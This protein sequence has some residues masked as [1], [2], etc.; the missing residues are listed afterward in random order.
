MGSNKSRDFY[1]GFI[2]PD[3][4]YSVENIT[5]SSHPGAPSSYTQEGN[6]TGTPALSSGTSRMVL[7]GT[8]DQAADSELSITTV[9]GGHPGVEGGGFT[10]TDEAN[11]SDAFGRDG[12]QIITSWQEIRSTTVV[13]GS[14]PALDAIR[15]QDGNLLCCG[16][17]TLLAG[18]YL[19]HIKRYGYT[20]G[21]WTSAATITPDDTGRQR[22]PALLQLP[23]GRV[24]LFLVAGPGQTQ[25]DVM[26]SDDAGSTWEYHAYRVL[27]TPMSTATRVLRAEYSNGEILLIC[28]TGSG[29]TADASVYASDD[30]ACQF[31]RVVT[32]WA[33]SVDDNAAA[34]DIVAST[35]GGFIIIYADMDVGS[36]TYHSRRI[37]SAFVSPS[38]STRVQVGGGGGEGAA[39][40]RDEDL[41]LYAVTQVVN[42]STTGNN[43][44]VFRSLDEGDSWDAF[45]A[46]AYYSGDGTNTWLFGFTVAST[47]GK[48]A[49]ITRWTDDAGYPATNPYA[50]F[51]I[52]AIW[53]GGS[54]THTVP[55]ESWTDSFKDTEYITWTDNQDPSA[56][57]F[58]GACYLPV[59][60]PGD[61][62]WGV[63][64]TG[65]STLTINADLQLEVSCAAGM[66]AAM[67]RGGVQ[68]ETMDADALF[69]EFALSV[70]SG[71]DQTAEEIYARGRIT[72]ESSYDY[73]I[74]L[75]F[76][77]NG[78]TA[79]DVNGASVGTTALTMGNPTHFRV[80]VTKGKASVWYTQDRATSD[81]PAIS[82][83]EAQSAVTL[84]D[85]GAG[86][87]A[88]PTI[89]WGA[90][91]GAGGPST[92]AWSM[93]GYCFWAGGWTPR[94]QTASGWDTPEA[95]HPRSYSTAPELIAD[96]AYVHAVSGPTTFGDSWT[97]DPEYH[98]Q[99]ANILPSVAPSP[100]NTWRGS[101][102]VSNII[103]FQLTGP[104][105][106][107]SAFLQDSPMLGFALFGINFKQAILQ[108]KVGAS[109][110]DVA[111]I[112]A[113][114]GGFQ[115]PT[116]YERFGNRVRPEQSTNQFVSERF[117]NWG[118]FTGGTFKMDGTYR[119]IG[120]NT[121]GMFTND[122]T[123]YPVFSLLD[124]DSADPTSGDCEV[125]SP[126]ACVIVSGVTPYNSQYFRLVI[127]AQTTAGDSYVEIGTM[128]VGPVVAFSSQYSW[129]RSIGHDAATTTFDLPDG[130]SKPRQ[131]G[132][133]AREF[134]FGWRDGVDGS[135]VDGF[136][137]S[138][139]YI[140]DASGGYMAAIGA[141]LYDLEGIFTEL[142][143]SVKPL[144]Y[145]PRIDQT[146]TNDQFTGPDRFALCRMT[147]SLNRQT[148]LGNEDSS[149]LARL[150]TVTLKEIK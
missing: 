11:D 130:S 97:I 6:Y 47:A 9:R 123:K 108:R 8:G 2:L 10:W 144:V 7:E 82:W 113:A 27:G 146:D 5:R 23:S 76:D 38:G 117:V 31:T 24:L 15:L 141:Q 77:A 66:S 67:S 49:L 48:T 45:S 89:S 40:W 58:N 46:P 30:L 74:S 41:T 90:L 83:T 133:V 111:T 138:P 33:S 32:S 68:H 73:G 13:T 44:Q 78:Y 39:I 120:G 53:L 57:T 125:W 29:G 135:T 72:D 63:S 119:R 103:G 70:T 79:Y 136:E 121:S 140:A 145:L 106:G 3:P 126:N 114:A 116:K 150:N 54:A 37:P 88:V 75:R 101:N 22:G 59:A 122:L 62:G 131:D 28:E 142:Q 19:Q 115:G 14:T 71:G 35:G 127:P 69:F 17:Q 99:I 50:F 139:D 20:T 34:F 94:M 61:L 137:Q 18:D 42:A 98:Y 25:V 16:D 36:E 95:L 55:A 134:E 56:N 21:E 12:P 84:A 105:M 65:G 85:G 147:G 93:V 110:V 52:A 109:W 43:V 118:D 81:K 100:R 129:G 102:K 107:V 124:V 149:E 26:R 104:N 4:R 143:G 132:P 1:Q 92:A 112:D 80:M 86:G 128:V 91:C 64:L 51:S 148:V 96:G 87:G 60:L